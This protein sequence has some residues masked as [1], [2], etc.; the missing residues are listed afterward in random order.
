MP[1]LRKWVRLAA[2]ETPAGNTGHDSRYGYGKGHQRSC[3]TLELFPS[4]RILVMVPP[5]DLLVQTAQAV[6]GGRAP[7][8]DG[9]GALF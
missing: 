2:R 5:L 9:R 1:D 3:D 8:T 4:G 7:G 6:A